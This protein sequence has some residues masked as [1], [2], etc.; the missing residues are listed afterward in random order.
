M[1]ILSKPEFKSELAIIRL[2]NNISKSSS[3]EKRSSD[4][5]T[6]STFGGTTPAGLAVELVHYRELFSKLRFSHNEQVT[7]EKFLKA[8]TSDTPLFIEPQENAR[9]EAQLAEEKA[10]L[11]A[12]KEA[13]AKMA[14]DLERKGKELARRYEQIELQKT[15]LADLPEQIANLQATIETLR[16]EHPSPAKSSNPN[17]NLPLPATLSLLSERESELSSLDAQIRA[18]QNNV[19]RKTRELE[20]LE[21]ELQPLLA[22]KKTVVGQAKEARKRKE[23]GGVEDMEQKGRW[24]RASHTALSQMLGTE[25]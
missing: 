3:A 8:L 23:E 1:D 10:A 25:S 5:S 13:V 20:R 6:D 2:A 19:P 15:I 12:H 24:Y 21:S 7:K 4:V 9:L 14:E 16:T 18:L 11:K 22:Q 17:L